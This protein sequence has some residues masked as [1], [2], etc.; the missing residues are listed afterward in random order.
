[1]VVP[2]GCID[3]VLIN[4]EAPMVIGP[5]TEPFAAPQACGTVI[6]GA[7]FHP[8]RAPGLLGLPASTLINQSVSLEAVWSKAECAQF[9][10]IIEQ[11]GLP[12]RRAAMELALLDRLAHAGAVDETM[13]AAIQWLA[14]HP[15][16]RIEQVSEWIGIGE[17]QLRRRFETAVGYG[18][19]LFQA[20]LRFQRLLHLSVPVS[21]PR[22]LAQLSAN[23]G[24][25][26]QAHMTRE[27]RRFAGSPPTVALR[28]A[29]CALRLS[30]LFKTDAGT[31]I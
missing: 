19:K 8:G 10:R 24:Y 23:V 4:D 12:A 30:D 9:V 27:V 14:G 26:D 2:D 29:I 15:D 13:S 25:A 7:R 5:W 6:L 18:P 11:E 3:I 20:V 28:S 31:P 1:V 17:R 16:G 21:A 22:N